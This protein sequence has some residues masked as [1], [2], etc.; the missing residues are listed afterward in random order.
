M[1]QLLS[2]TSSAGL[3]GV[4]P[5][6]P[7]WHS[8]G[9]T[10]FSELL[11]CE[12]AWGLKRW[13]MVLTLDLGWLFQ[14]DIN[15]FFYS[16]FQTICLLWPRC[17][18]CNVNIQD[19]TNVDIYRQPIQGC[20]GSSHPLLDTVRMQNSYFDDEFGDVMPQ[21]LHDLSWSS[22]SCPASDVS[23]Q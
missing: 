8:Q 7:V 6:N 21:V 1:F 20:S 4:Q 11:K 2:N 3:Q 16:F 5:L 22:S 12:W 18:H 13:L 17:L 15:G 9:D 10:W 14:F 23:H 19:P